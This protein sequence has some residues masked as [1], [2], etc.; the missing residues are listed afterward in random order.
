[1][2]RTRE[3]EASTPSKKIP[4]T[5][6]ALVVDNGSGMCKA[7]FAS[8][9]TPRCVFP[10][11]VGTPKTE[12][13]IVDSGKDSY[14]GD[15]AQSKRGVLRLSYPIAHGVVTDWEAMERVWHHTF[16]DKLR[17]SPE[18][19]NVMLT[20]APM[21]PKSNREKMSTI[22]FETFNVQ[23]L[24]VSIQA[25]LSLYSSGRTTGVVLDCGDGVSHCVPVYEG[26]S[27]PHAVQRLDLAG[28][29]L[30][31]FMVRL[32]REQGHN[33]E[34]TSGH[35]I[36]KDI[37]ERL[38]YVA[39]DY[40][41]E[42]AA[43]IDPTDYELPDGVVIKVGQEQFRCPEALFNPDLMGVESNGIHKLL[44]TT[45]QKCDMDVR[46]D[47]Y[48][49]CVLSGATTSF[50]GLPQRLDQELRDLA[51]TSIKV[52]VVAPAERKYSV[53]IGGSILASLPSFQ[54]MWITKEQYDEVGPGIIHKKCWA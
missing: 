43:T 39:A 13:V 52:R 25:V 35:E 53:W 41:K 50:R 46:R 26:Y 37:K 30:N 44:N 31:R 42:L 21:N 1:M 15:D 18:G 2:K 36:A 54:T 40:Q 29:D 19:Y 24:Y 11:I 27:M 48:N 38:C 51:P 10:S 32:L 23:G 6:T 9:T 14:I 17:V 47:L 20:E 34:T 22:M 28:R 8:D 49:N 4:D 45:I 7:G 16:Y 33:L 5:T 12:S 3:T